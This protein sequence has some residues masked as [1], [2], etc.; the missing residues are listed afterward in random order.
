MTRDADRQT[1]ITYQIGQSK[2]IRS[3]IVNSLEIYCDHAFE[4]ARNNWSKRS[5]R[6]LPAWRERTIARPG[7]NP[8]RRSPGRARR[9]ARRPRIGWHRHRASHRDDEIDRPTVWR[10]STRF[11]PRRSEARG[12]GFCLAATADQRC[13]RNESR[14]TARRSASRQSSRRPTRARP[15]GHTT[16]SCL[17]PRPRGNAAAGLQ[18]RAI[19]PEYRDAGRQREAVCWQAG[20]DGVEMPSFTEQTKTGD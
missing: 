12:R 18:R 16:R 9:R 13:G 4:E 8:G 2:A 7:E 14:R 11:F 10:P 3:V 19:P 17:S 1:D 5:A 15:C 6:T 20:W